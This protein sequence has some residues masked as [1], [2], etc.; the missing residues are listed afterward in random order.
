LIVSYCSVRAPAAT[1]GPTP[2][3]IAVFLKNLGSLWSEL[4]SLA[5]IGTD[6]FYDTGAIISAKPFS[7]ESYSERT[8]LMQEI[9]RDGFEL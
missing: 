4:D 3:D 1:N 6:I 8:A 7:A 2:I 9:R 5:A